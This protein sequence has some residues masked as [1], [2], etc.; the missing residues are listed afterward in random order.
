LR[1]RSKASTVEE[2]ELATIIS[3]TYT[4]MNIVIAPFL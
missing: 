4:N 1:S 2:E 3:S